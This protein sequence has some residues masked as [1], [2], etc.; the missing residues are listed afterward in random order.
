MAFPNSKEEA[1][2]LIYVKSQDLSGKTPEEILALYEEAK[3]RIAEEE[4]KDSFG[5]QVI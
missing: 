5:A 3:K 2:A 1:L 4:S